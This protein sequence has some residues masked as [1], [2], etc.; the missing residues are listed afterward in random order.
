MR[1]DAELVALL[2]AEAR[3]ERE[4]YSCETS[5]L[6]SPEQGSAICAAWDA[7][8]AALGAAVRERINAEAQA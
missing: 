2:L 6:T 3:A 7:A 8:R 1:T 5:P 4:W